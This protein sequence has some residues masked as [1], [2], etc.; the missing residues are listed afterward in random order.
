M[1]DIESSPS[2]ADV[3]SLWNTTVSL[4]QL[5][6]SSRVICFAAKWAGERKTLFWSE[7]RDGH[8]E[9]VRA[10]HSLLSEADVVVDYNGNKFDRPMMNREFAKLRLGPPAPYRAIDLYRVIRKQFRF[11]SNKLEFVLRDLELPEKV[12]HEG[13]SLWVKCMAGD[14]RAWKSME[15]Y[16]RQ[17]VGSLEALHDRV[18]PW[19]TTYPSRRLYDGDVCPNCTRG[20]LVREG[21]AYTAVGKYQRYSCKHCG[22]WSR[23]S[24]RIDGVDIQGV[25]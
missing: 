24:R 12:K 17:D 8:E 10:A 2:L 7:F 4:S 20:E 11:P 16:N 13:H 9:M 1:W 18:L 23:G 22:T 14:A 6:E 19:I 21:Y 5:R 3:W 15:R 25:V